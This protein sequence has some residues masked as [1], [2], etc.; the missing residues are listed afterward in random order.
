MTPRTLETIR[1]TYYVYLAFIL[2]V[3]WF[4]TD[5]ADQAGSSA[6]L[7]DRDDLESRVQTLEA[8]MDATQCGCLPRGG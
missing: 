3:A 5:W 2:L 8:A 7:H 4:F 1:T 6:V